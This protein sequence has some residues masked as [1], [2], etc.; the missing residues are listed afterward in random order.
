MGICNSSDSHLSEEEKLRRKNE[1]MH[2]AELAA[3]LQ[4]DHEEDEDVS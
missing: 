4:K 1:A 2:S 3:R